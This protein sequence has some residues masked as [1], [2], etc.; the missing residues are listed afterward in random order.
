[1]A[2]SAKPAFGGGNK[3]VKEEAEE[4]GGKQTKKRVGGPV[5]ASAHSHGGRAARKSGGACESHLFSSAN[6]GSPAPGRK[7]MSKKV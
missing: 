3:D 6:A 7:L 1:M 2:K 5:G 4:K